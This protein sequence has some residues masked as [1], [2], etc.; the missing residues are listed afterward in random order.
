LSILELVHA[1]HVTLVLPWLVLL[2]VAG[3][4]SP[5]VT[6]RPLA[7]PTTAT[8]PLASPVQTIVIDAGHGGHDPG[9]AHYGLQEKHLA[10]DIVKRLRADLQ[11]RGLT[12]VTTRET[13]RFIPLSGRPAIANRLH[14]DLFI[15]VHINANRHRRVSGV[16]VDYPRVSVVSSAAPWPPTLTASEVAIPSTTVKQTL[17]DVVLRGTRSDSRRLAVAICRSMRQGLQAPCR[18]VRGARFVVLLEAAMPAVLVEV[19]YVS[20]R[21]EAQR[22]SSAAYRQRAA[23]A[24]ADGITQYIRDLG[25]QHI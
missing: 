4:S 8:R 6:G 10:L 25:A 14:A 12:V 23:H 17:W 13:D 9:T 3:C 15:S 2:G 11:Q 1:L 19:G 18:G 16:E 22:L 20:N 5:V 21:A 24:I 7:S